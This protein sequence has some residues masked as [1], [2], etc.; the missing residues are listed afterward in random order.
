[1]LTPSGAAV[2]ARLAVAS[3]LGAFGVGVGP[4]AEHATARAAPAGRMSSPGVCIALNGNLI[5]I[6]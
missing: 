2:A 5:R 3:C 4:I 6:A 1:M